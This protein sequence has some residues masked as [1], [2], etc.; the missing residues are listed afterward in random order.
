MKRIS[1][2]TSPIEPGCFFYR[3]ATRVSDAIDRRFCAAGD[4]CQIA[5]KFDNALFISIHFN[6]GGAG[7]GLETYTWHRVGVPV[8]DG[9]WPADFRTWPSAFGNIR[10]A[11]NMALA[12]ATHAAL[13]VRS[14]MYDRG[15]KRARFV[16]IRDITVPGVLIEGGFL[17]NPYDAKLI[18]TTRIPASRWRPA[19]VQAIGNYRRAVAPQAESM[20]ARLQ[21]SLAWGSVAGLGGVRG[22]ADRNHLLHELAW[23]AKSVKN[24]RS[25]VEGRRPEGLKSKVEGRGSKAEAVHARKPSG[26]STLDLR[27]STPKV[28]P[29]GVFDSGVGGLTGRGSAS[30]TA[31]GGEYFLHWRHRARSLR[32]Q[33]AA[34]IERYSME[35]SGLLLAEQAKIIVVACNTASA[36]AVPRLQ[37]TLKI[38]VIGVIVPGA[39]AAVRATRNGRIGVIGTR[40]TIYSRAYERAIHEIAPKTKV[41]SSACPLLVPLIEEGWLNDPVADQVIERYLEGLVARKSIHS[42]SDARITRFC[43]RPSK[44]SSAR[45]LPLS[46]PHR[47]ARMPSKNCWTIQNLLHRKTIS[48]S[49]VSPL[50]DPVDGFLH[51]A[52]SALR[53]QVGDVQLRTVQG[54]PAA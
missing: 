53:L 3:R 44:N 54:V 36:L 41:I 18:A 39:Q 11:E 23:A 37:E 32:G 19:Y 13:V 31:A 30:R 21:A 48:G 35:I 45:Q 24:R 46:I 25:R 29:I 40:A 12:T 51:V 17:S 16:V 8:N 15:I 1:P 28:P 5:S 7:T 2:S 33:S 4:P 20:H 49:S 27:R 43:E 42:F 9:G 10:D 47:T 52:E 26:R 50:P 14:K 6:S 34:T 38:P 22:R